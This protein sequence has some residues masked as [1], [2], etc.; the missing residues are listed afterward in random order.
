MWDASRKM[1]SWSNIMLH[2][3]VL[4]QLSPSEDKNDATVK[5][6]IINCRLAKTHKEQGSLVSYVLVLPC[7]EGHQYSWEY[8]LEE[9]P[10]L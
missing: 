2:H 9:Y 10:K 3:T 8:Q 6:V 5:Y 7:M 1:K 4:F